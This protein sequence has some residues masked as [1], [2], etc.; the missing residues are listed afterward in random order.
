MQR[1]VRRF[2]RDT[3]EFCRVLRR[4][5]AVVSG[6][7]LLQALVGEVWPE[8]DMDVYVDS[9]GASNAVADFLLGSESYVFDS[10]EEGYETVSVEAWLVGL[11]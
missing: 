3:K 5:G 8:S 10:N 1:V 6:G 2:I 11:F 7:L 4:T 9:E